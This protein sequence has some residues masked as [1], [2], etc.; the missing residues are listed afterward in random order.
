MAHDDHAHH[1]DFDHG[2]DHAG[3]GH[4]GHAH[5]KSGAHSQ[6][7]GHSHGHAHGHAHGH[8][9][10]NETRIALAGLVTGLFLIVEVVGGLMSG[11]LAL[12]ADAGHMVSDFAAL[13]LAWF[14]FRI[15]RRP[16]DARRTF[17]FRRFSV[18][19]AF[20][21]GVA[22][23]VVS[24]W[25]VVEAVRRLMDPAPVDAVP[26]L[27]VAAGGLLANV[28]SFL[29]LHGADRD[30]LN[31][32]GAFLHV[33]GDLLGSV[34]AIAAGVVILMTGWTAADPILSAVVA[35]I[36]LNTAQRLV[37]ESGH[38]LLEGAPDHIDV[39][40]VSEDIA[41]NID[42]VLDVHHAHAWSIDEARPMMTLHARVADSASGPSVASR[43]R[44]RLVQRHGVGHATIEIEDGDC[45]TPGCA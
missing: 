35:A 39:D 34:A 7:H 6:G 28:V 45:T 22:L 37:R 12:L 25:I 44:E 24:L 42:G 2:H 30:N 11:S 14:G 21:N 40:A 38:I 5:G 26:M 8:G 29:I 17:G 18:L 19:A 1:A 27:W 3:H 16:A 31:M 15:A 36:I 41:A 43:I 33:V 32:R 20:V 23:I 13:G 9:D 4:G 10:G